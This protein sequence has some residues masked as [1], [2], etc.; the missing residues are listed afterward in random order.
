MILQ[1]FHLQFS[2]KVFQKHKQRSKASQKLILLSGAV[3]G[4]YFDP[5]RFL[6]K[7]GWDL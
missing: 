3:S 6:T 5:Y 7:S 1:R 4:L 2:L